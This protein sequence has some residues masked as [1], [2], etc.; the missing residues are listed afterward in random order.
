MEDE[1]EEEYVCKMMEVEIGKK[2]NLKER[3]VKDLKEI[4]EVVNKER[5]KVA[6]V[7]RAVMESSK[8]DVRKSLSMM[9]LVQSCME[10]LNKPP[11]EWLYTKID[12]MKKYLAGT[13]MRI[14]LMM[15]NAIFKKTAAY[16]T[17]QDLVVKME[18]GGGEMS[19][20]G[21]ERGGKRE[22]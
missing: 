5:S 17:P 16:Y 10:K 9:F 11:G 1:D 22:I 7:I 13:Y 4:L 21:M 15:L 8:E 3:M 20:E 6:D 19:G 14:V 18:C 12:N 2:G